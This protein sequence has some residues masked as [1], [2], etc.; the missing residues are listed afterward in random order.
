MESLT[1]RLL[2]RFGPQVAQWCAAVPELLARLASRWGLVL[3]GPLPDGASSVTLRCR[4]P[5]GTPAVLKIG[6]ERELLA[7]QAVMLGWFA[8]SGRVPAVLA[9]D[10]AAGAMVLE[11]VVPGTPVAELSGPDPARW[12]EL[13][14][15]LHG[16]APAATTP[17]LLRGRMEEAF[18]RV[19]RRLAEP[20]V[21]AR[22]DA[23]AW[24]L[25][26][27]R[28][29][30]LLDTETRTVLLHGDLHPGNVLD[31]GAGRGL[32]AIDPKAC[33]GD[34]CFD[35]VDFVVAGAG[36]EG[37][38][39]RCAGVAAAYGLDPDRLH[40]WSRVDAAFAAVARLGAGDEGPAVEELLALTR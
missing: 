2:G 11:E 14:A 21:G 3:G 39:A 22:M 33:A 35:A 1:A 18:A 9:L 19:G 17:R 8:P 37:V 40:A 30:R 32:V 28:C 6:P 10:A 36:R 31:G 38:E 26:L 16:A 20:A 7:E 4:W 27:R 25:A 23:A 15:A 5:D 29:E 24:D 13:M 12:A 34:P